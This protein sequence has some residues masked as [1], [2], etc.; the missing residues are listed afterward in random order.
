MALMSLFP[1]GESAPGPGVD[2]IRAN[3]YAVMVESSEIIEAARKKS[4]EILA[5]AL[6]DAEELRELA[7]REGLEEGKAEVADQLFNAVTASVEQMGK[8]ES[9][10][11]DVVVQSIRA[12]LG[13]F[14]EHDLVVR[15][16]GQAIR[17]VR[18]EKRVTLRVSLA[19]ADTVRNQLEDILARYPGIGRV[20]VRPDASVAPGGCVMETEMGVI[21]ATLDRQLAIIRDTF[22]KTLQERT[23]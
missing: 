11:V 13:E 19:D 20:D 8:M 14:D 2:V 18:D 6:T 21:D 16:V 1:N 7:R 5:Q 12:I 4:A 9:G 17:L 22:H 10:L 23:A 15:V 3:E